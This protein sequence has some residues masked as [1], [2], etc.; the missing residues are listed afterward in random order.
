MKKFDNKIKEEFSSFGAIAAPL[1]TSVFLLLKKKAIFHKYQHI[2]VY[3]GIVFLS[4]IGMYLLI[5]N[6]I[7]RYI[8]MNKFI[9]GYDFDLNNIFAEFSYNFEGSNKELTLQKFNLLN[10]NSDVLI[11]KQEFEDKLKTF[12]NNIDLSNLEQRNTNNISTSGF[13][14]YLKFNF[15]II[16]YE[17]NLMKE[18]LNITDY[19]IFSFI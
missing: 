15:L 4:N 12:K 18:T 8:Y 16:K 17:R 1:M 14:S 6:S 2:K 7:T 3:F 5:N 11:K 19:R 10:N 9:K 13:F